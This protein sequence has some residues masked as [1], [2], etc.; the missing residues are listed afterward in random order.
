VPSP[1]G[2]RLLDP[3]ATAAVVLGAHDW[4][5]AGLGRAPS[6]LRSARGVVAYLYDPAGLGLDPDLVL[7]LFDDPAGAGD[8]LVRLQDTLDVLLRERRDAGRPVADVLIYYVG[9]GHTNDEGHLSLLVR[10]SRRGMEAE[11]GIRAP[12]LAQVL[13]RAA[14]QQRRLVILDC[15]F[16]EAAAR[17]FIGMGGALEQAVAATAARGLRDAQPSRG[18]LLL[19]S[20]PVGDV[21][22]GAPDSEQTLFTGAV[23]DVLRK[24]A[25]EFPPAL[26]FANLRDQ[27]Y[28]RMLVSFG[29]NAP[30]P[31]LHPVN[32]SQGDLTQLPAFPN[33]VS[34]RPEEQGSSVVLQETT[35]RYIAERAPADRYQNL[36]QLIASAIEAFEALDV[37]RPDKLA[38]WL[39]IEAALRAPFEGD[40]KISSSRLFLGALSVGDALTNDQN[41]RGW[42]ARLRANVVASDKLRR[43]RDINEKERFYLDGARAEWRLKRGVSPNVKD[44]IKDA[45]ATQTDKSVTGD[46]IAFSL[47]FNRATL[48]A[49][50]L[51][52]YD[53]TVEELRA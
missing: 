24:G 33:R 9:H 10:R 25:A 20:S 38:I 26:S 4:T 19:C 23:L 40:P 52:K 53:V 34:A 14:P 41:G 46:A 35:L 6:F 21:S 16:S 29:A 36:D 8:Q 3:R 17:S 47:L 48:L 22:I 5:D 49:K 28:E 45:A 13:K 2:A 43:F 30:R 50:W 11:T 31:V 7:D 1:F 44:I 15:C 37:S 51:K 39:I 32:Q 27:A 12:D 42:I 18:G